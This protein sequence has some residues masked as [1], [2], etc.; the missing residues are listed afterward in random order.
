M[1]ARRDHFVYW[2]YDEAGR[3]LYV[4]ITRFPEQRLRQHRRKAW[5]PK[6]ATK[7]MAGP[8]TKETAR[9]LERE[10]QDELQPIHDVR[11]RAMRGRALSLPK[12]E[13]SWALADIA[14]RGPRHD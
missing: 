11:Q 5:F 2:M 10:E 7:R 12:A 1:S 6:V 13:T 8:F 4:G 3:T 9:K 14:I